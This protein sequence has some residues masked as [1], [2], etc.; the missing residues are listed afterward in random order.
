MT[1]DLT[2]GERIVLLALDEK[3]GT[4]REAPLRVSLAVSAAALLE[5]SSSGG[6]TERDGTLVVT[7]A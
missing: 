4:L 5:L 7:G 6:L 2:I 1:E 3:A